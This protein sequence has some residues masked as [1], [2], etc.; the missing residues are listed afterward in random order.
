M[1]PSQ[2]WPTDRPGE[3]A[4]A[5]AVVRRREKVVQ[6]TG[7]V[8]PRRPLT[9]HENGGTEE[10]YPGRT[11]F[12]ADHPVVA[13]NPELFE[14]A[15]AKDGDTI[16]G[17]QKLLERKLRDTGT[18]TRAVRTTTSSRWRLNPPSRGDSRLA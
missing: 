16:R 17:L 7:R 15:D 2:S 11:R 3:I 13:A 5:N 1:S 12:A 18:E 4:V 8:T 14:P 6:G 9:L 10:L